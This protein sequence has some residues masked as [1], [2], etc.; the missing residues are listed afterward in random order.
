MT[1]MQI[2]VLLAALSV[3]APVFAE[4]DFPW[5]PITSVPYDPAEGCLY[6]G[7]RYAEG[8]VVDPVL[9][10]PHQCVL[11][12]TDPVID[13]SSVTQDK[14]NPLFLFWEELEGS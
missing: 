12:S 11:K 2:G 3:S 14:E 8:E 1:R 6:G 7:E 9:L 13:D 10:P 5:R 4:M